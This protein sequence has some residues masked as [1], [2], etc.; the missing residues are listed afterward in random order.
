MSESTLAKDAIV[1]ER[2]F[3]APIDLIWQLWTQPEHFKHWYGPADFRV[4]AAEVDLRVGGQHLICMEKTDGSMKFWTVGEYTE[5]I[6]H[7]RL[8]YTDSM[9]DETGRILLPAE[10]GMPDEYPI[11]TVVTVL[12]EDLDGRTKM[13]MTHAGVPANE[14][15][16]SAGWEQAFD[17]LIAYTETILKHK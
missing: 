9:A 17:K 6:P 3:D 14:E 2:I 5:I 7:E 10:F 8:V 4:V 13:V 11:K 15:G 1:V 16:A 12:L